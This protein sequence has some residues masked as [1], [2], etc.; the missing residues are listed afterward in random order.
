[1]KV[2]RRRQCG[3]RRDERP[4]QSLFDNDP[5]AQAGECDAELRGGD[6]AV[7]MLDRGN[8]GRGPAKASL[9]QLFHARFAHGNKRELGGDEKSVGRQQQRKRRHAD[10]RP[11]R[12]HATPRRRMNWIAARVGYLRMWGKLPS[13]PEGKARG[14]RNCTNKREQA[15]SLLHITSR[16]ISLD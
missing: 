10:D 2:E 3:K 14:F 9:L 13:L 16:A 1:E 6:V 4:G 5:K 8:H 11:P 12:L 7:E 15:G